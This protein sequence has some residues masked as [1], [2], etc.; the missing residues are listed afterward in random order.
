MNFDL[1]NDSMFEQIS[2]HE[3]A[4]I[5]GGTNGTSCSCVSSTET[6]TK[7]SSDGCTD[8]GDID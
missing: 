7:C 6:G 3:M 8:C 4:A 2:L 5:Q 1:I